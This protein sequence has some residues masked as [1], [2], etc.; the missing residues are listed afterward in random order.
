MGLLSNCVKTT[1]LANFSLANV[2]YLNNNFLFLAILE[3][4]MY[5]TVPTYNLPAKYG[6]YFA[7]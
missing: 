4:L 2:L 7:I 5:S 1:S 6:P 3:Y